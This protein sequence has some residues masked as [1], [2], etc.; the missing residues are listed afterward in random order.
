MHNAFYISVNF[1][2]LTRKKTL[3]SLALMGCIVLGAA[4]PGSPFDPRSLQNRTP[5]ITAEAQNGPGALFAQRSLTKVRASVATRR[6]GAK[7]AV[8]STANVLLSQD[9]QLLAAVSYAHFRSTQSLVG[10]GRSPPGF[11]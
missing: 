6:N 1:P 5:W 4:D 7:A 10:F 9:S 8:K 11:F 3:L 2:S